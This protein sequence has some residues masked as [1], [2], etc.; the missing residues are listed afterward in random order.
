MS[1][2][3]AEQK[4]AAW[5]GRLVLVGAIAGAL[6][7]AFDRYRENERDLAEGSEHRPRAEVQIRDME[8]TV[9]DVVDDLAAQRVSDEEFRKSALGAIGDGFTKHDERISGLEDRGKEQLFLIREQR[10]LQ[11]IERERVERVEDQIRD[12]ERRTRNLVR[13]VRDRPVEVIVA[14]T[15][16]TP[17]APPPPTE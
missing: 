4:V 12:S 1:I 14:P 15:P 8:E 17:N 5:W 10:T 6:Y 7:L 13:A 3:E 16:I 9:R 2:K 11:T